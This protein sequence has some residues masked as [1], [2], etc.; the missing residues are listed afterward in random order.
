MAAQD[1]YQLLGVKRDATQ[2]E[3]RRAYRKLAKQHHPDL[4][5]GSKEAEDRFKAISGAHDILSD[6]DKRARF[7]R[8]EID[9][10]G[11]EKAPEHGY[12][13]QHAE[14]GQGPRYQRAGGFGA[15]DS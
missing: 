10:S 8:G 6:A 2:D 14:G 5:P 7:D 11:A 15:G 12:Y 3:I 4:N 1:P 13:R 9:G